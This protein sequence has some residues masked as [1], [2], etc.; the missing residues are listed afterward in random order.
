ML[1]VLAACSEPAPKSGGDALA[2]APD[3]IRPADA[4]DDGPRAPDGAGDVGASACKG[5]ACSSHGSCVVVD[6]QPTCACTQ[7][8]Y[9]VGLSCLEDPCA[10]GGSCYYVDSAAGD[11]GN[12]GSRA[13]PWKTVD[14]VKSAL[15]GLA[16]GGHVLFRRGGDWTSAPVTITGVKG[17]DG[18][19]VT[20]GAYGPSGA[21]RPKLSKLALRSSSHVTLRDFEVSFSTAGP[22]IVVTET[23]HVIIQDTVVH[24]CQS[25]GILFGAETSHGVMVDNQSYEIKANDALV[26]HSPMNLTSAN[27]VGDHHWIIDN[28]VPGPA[29]EQAV[30]VATGSD[31]VEGCRD[32]KIV[33]NRLARGKAGC[34]VTGHATSVVWIIGN[35]LGNCPTAQTAHA[36]RVG[37][38]HGAN[39]GTR[40]Q[41]RGNV[42]FWTLMSS[43]M[44][45]EA[46]QVPEAVVEHN[47]FVTA[48]G[49]RAV[50]RSSYDKGK[51]DFS[52]NIVWTTGGQA[53]VTLDGAPQDSISAMDHNWYIPGTKPAC[54]I[55]G[56]SL[57]EWQAATGFDASS[58]CGSVPGLSLP[59]KAEAE[60]LESWTQPAFLDRFIPDAS[61]SGCAAGIGAFD[62]NGKLRVSF[63][64]IAGYSDNQGYGWEGPLIVRQR[65][66]LP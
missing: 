19:P 61:W 28:R 46:P 57:A 42:V 5:V 15:S 22:C 65:Y 49:E 35:M 51:L 4:D 23:D 44:T 63:K 34:I 2:P 30:D 12:P 29:A 10:G 1:A 55:D 47:T 27:K 8:Y 31:T 38:A 24:D 54:S 66:P 32:V 60:D 9:R 50:W 14:R 40:Y 7:S 36:I 18:K 58:S 3:T 52:R 48:V 21:A 33:G 17:S 11:D 53:H 26:I 59:T 13:K 56:K 6:G 20:F 43:G 37:G 41:I 62:C 25:N 45:S 39:S 64:P 16:P